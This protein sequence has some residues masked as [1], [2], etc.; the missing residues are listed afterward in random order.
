MTIYL[1]II[2]LENFILNFIILCAVGVVIKEKIRYLKLMIASFV[3]AI[4]VIIYYLINFQSKWNLIFKIILSVVMVYISFMPKS[5][6]EFIKQITFFYLV[7]FVFGGASLG[8]IYMVNAGK[9]SIR[10]GIIVGNYTLKTIFIGVIL[11]FTII[12]VAFKFVKNRISKKDLFCN[13][14]IIINQSKIN[15]KAVIDTGNFLKEPI[16]NIPVIVVEKDILKNFVPREILENIENILGGDLKNI[17]ENIQNEYM[18]KLKVIPFSSLGKQNGMLLGI[19]ADGVVVEIDNEE[20]YVEKY[21][22][23]VILG[24]Y[25]KKLSKKDEYNALLGIDVI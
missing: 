17:P 1:D 6:K 3:G 8:V 4:Y 22:E 20:K 13:I 11:A 5:F 9:I 24:I 14:K 23:K 2:F 18:S 25:T 7:S 19:K 21:V 10:N 12:T 16:T 15:V